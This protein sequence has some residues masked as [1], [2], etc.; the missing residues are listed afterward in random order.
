MVTRDV[1]EDVREREA[2][3][4][5]WRWWEE[6]H[7]ELLAQYPEQFVV[8]NK[9]REVIGAYPHLTDACNAIE[10]MG[11]DFRDDVDLDF[12]TDQKSWHL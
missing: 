3:M 4:A 5:T 12:I 11:L 10:A 6:H 2:A 7:E 9:A 1:S 8:I